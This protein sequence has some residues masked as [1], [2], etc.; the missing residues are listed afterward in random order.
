MNY[1]FENDT[2]AVIKKL[3]RKSVR[4]D[5]KKNLFCLS[6]IIVAV[7][8]IMMSLLTVQNIIYQNQKEIEGLHQGIFFDIT[9]DS[10]EKLLA[11][12][13][14]KSVGLSCNIKTVKE[15]SKELSLIYYDDDMLSLIPA[16]D[17]KYPEKASEIAGNYVEIT[18]LMDMFGL[19]MQ[20][21]L[22]KTKQQKYYLKFQRRLD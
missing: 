1:P 12:E 8:M 17:G 19:K 9:Q 5:K 4:F 10:K 6:A 16:F 11:N 20:I 22:Q 14:V 21:P 15:N 2:S 3:A 13:E 7:A 18:C